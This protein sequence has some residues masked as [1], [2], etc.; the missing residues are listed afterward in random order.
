MKNFGET[1]PRK[2]LRTTGILAALGISL[3]ACTSGNQIVAAPQA[4]ACV[5]NISP[6]S[7]ANST[8]FTAEL[9]IDP[10][11]N[12]HLVGGSLTWGDG[13]SGEPALVGAA[14]EFKAHT[15][16]A[17]GTFSIDALATVDVGLGVPFRILQCENSVTIG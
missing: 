3:G 15:Y 8:E 4:S 10:V 5:L 7:K 12:G 6:A 16:S 14:L 11:M 17:K 2:A 1:R 9:Y 13:A